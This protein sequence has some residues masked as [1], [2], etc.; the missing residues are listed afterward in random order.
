[1]T[2]EYFDAD[3]ADAVSRLEDIVA[4]L[5]RVAAA[6]DRAEPS[7]VRLDR[8]IDALEEAHAALRSIHEDATQELL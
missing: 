1:V 5:R 4:R 8:Q 7:R 3:L 2:G 6:I